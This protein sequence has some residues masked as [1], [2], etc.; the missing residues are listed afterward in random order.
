MLKIIDAEY[1]NINSSMIIHPDELV[2]ITVKINTNTDEVQV[3]AIIKRPQ[4]YH[5]NKHES[6]VVAKYPY[7]EKLLC[8]SRRMKII[9]SAYQ[10]MIVEV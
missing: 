2:R 3:L 9:E 6:I 7:S 4:P 8:T 10:N 1:N 5:G